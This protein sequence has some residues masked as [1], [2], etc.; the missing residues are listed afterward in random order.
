MLRIVLPTRTSIRNQPTIPNAT[1]PCS[2]FSPLQLV[3]VGTR[4][5]RKKA[6]GSFSIHTI[7]KEKQPRA[8]RM[9]QRQQTGTGSAPGPSRVVTEPARSEIDS[10]PEAPTILRLRGRHHPDGRTVQW[11]EDVVDNEGLGRKSSKGAVPSPVSPNF[12]S[13]SSRVKD[14]NK[15]MRN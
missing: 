13:V 3:P 5:A 4:T 11:A 15:R 1:F 7:R 14:T 9:S 12:A 2:R 10:Q 6:S 8:E